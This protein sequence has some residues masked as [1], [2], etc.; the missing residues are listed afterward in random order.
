M[1]D[2]PALDSA[3]PGQVHC[4]LLRNVTTTDSSDHIPY[5]LAGFEGVAN[6]KYMFY[7]TPDDLNG[8]DFNNG[9]CVNASVQQ[10]VGGNYGYGWRNLPGGSG[11]DLGK[12]LGN[13]AEKQ[14]VIHWRAMW[15]IVHVVVGLL[16]W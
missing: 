3:F 4:I 16:L 7:N 9:D 8:L 13:N 15:V 5:N 12:L 2:Y 6:N 1:K 14:M 10:Y 11:L